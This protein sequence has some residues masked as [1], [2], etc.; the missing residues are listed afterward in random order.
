VNEDLELVREF[1]IESNSNLAN[2]EQQMVELEKSPQDDQLLGSIF[3]TIHTIKGTCGFFN[4]TK[5]ERITHS[6]ENLLS[7]LRAHERQLTPPLV[8]AILNS[9]DVVKAELS[10]IEAS[11]A[12][13][14]ES[15]DS[16]LQLLSAICE[17]R[18][19]ESLMRSEDA[20][21]EEPVPVVMPVP[22]TPVAAPKPQPPAN[23]GPPAPPEAKSPS[24]VD[25][26]IRVDIQVLDRLMN[27]VG[28][29]VLVRNQILQNETRSGR[30]QDSTVQRLNLL[31]S[32]LQE[33]VMKTR[34]QP[35]GSVWN[36][37]PRVV[38]DM[39]AALGKQILLETEGAETDL[40]RSV[41]EAIRDPLTHMVRNS[42]DHGI[43]RP[44][45]RQAAGKP[46]QGRLLLRAYHEGGQ[47]VVEIQ[48]DGAGIDAERLKSKAV[49]KGL[50]TE[51]QAARMS[52]REGLDLIFLA[53]FSTATT[54]TNISGRGVGMDVVRRNIEQI[55][56]HVELTS[57]VGEGTQFKIRIPLTLAI[58]PV[59]AVVTGGAQY[60]IPQMNL[61]KLL[62]LPGP[63][64]QHVEFVNESPV[65]RH[66][67][68]L[69]PLVYLDELLGLAGARADQQAR[70]RMPQTV[71]LL[72][73]ERATFG[74]AVD[75]VT[76]IREI[77]VKPFGKELK[78][79]PCYAGA[80][81]LGDGRVA[82]ILDVVG[83]ARLAGLRLDGESSNGGEAAA[84]PKQVSRQTL[85]LFSSGSRQRMGIP[86]TLVERLEKFK[87]EQV[88]LSDGV[89]AVQYYGA[90]LPLASMRA[91]LDPGVADPTFEQPSLLVLV[92]QREHR[93]IGLV[94]DRIH[95]IRTAAIGARGQSRDSKLLGTAVFDGKVTD[96]VNLPEVLDAADPTFLRPRSQ[97]RYG[98]QRILVASGSRFHRLAVR[99]FLE[100]AGH[101]VVEAST[102]EQAL[103][104]GGSEPLDLL[105]CALD[106]PPFGAEALVSQ[107]RA[108]PA[109]AA[110]PVIGLAGEASQMPEPGQASGPFDSLRAAFDRKAILQAID[111][112]VGQRLNAA[113]KTN[114]KESTKRRKS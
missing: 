65:I 26:A 30:R 34:M 48:D 79:L 107:W 102:A 53:G 8:T 66:R 18:P 86:L 41:L 114:R 59:L 78:N 88:E 32:E 109:L 84:Q 17:K 57:K 82:L 68:Q 89:P 74:L 113:P 35:V 64:G 71:I 15:H 101:H 38:R 60:L 106:L 16:L 25:T 20:A 93:R 52:V 3:R 67:G 91:V 105:C 7:Q 108:V 56:G 92:I 63:D 1:L 36:K 76:S 51:A 23:A 55:G 45:V 110:L 72:Q 97:Q 46:A 39:S 24:V 19:V 5:L 70:S 75:R 47:V 22:V 69:V 27:M 58:I 95:D 11:G 10:V 12:E 9:I 98:G 77:V 40:D 37:L 6:V 31:T 111:A 29:L 54:V 2:F 80:T 112:L 33:G 96:L 43:E 104:V 13:S 100:L 4:F 62:R 73:A 50:I 42:C 83:L 103:A 21:T 90:I 85:L 94:V 44:E 49:E 87:R 14:S 99:H 28:E 61:Q 81:I